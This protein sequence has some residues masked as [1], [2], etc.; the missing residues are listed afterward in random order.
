MRDTNSDGFKLHLDT[1]C[2]HLAGDD[3]EAVIRENVDILHHFHASE[4]F[5]KDFSNPQV[6]HEKIAQILKSVGYD[7]F[8]SIEMLPTDD[9]A[10]SVT[11]AINFVSK[12]YE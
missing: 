3:F 2:M 6:E 7:G 1:A 11:Q 10:T 4:P 8:V 9:A 5:L 12:I